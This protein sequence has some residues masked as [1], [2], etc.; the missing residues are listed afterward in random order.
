[1]VGFDVG[2]SKIKPIVCFQ[3]IY[4]LFRYAFNV[5]TLHTLK[6]FCSFMKTCLGLFGQNVMMRNYVDDDGDD[7]DDDDDINIQ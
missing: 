4:I 2:Y 6:L 1:M 3:A 5:Y 7:D